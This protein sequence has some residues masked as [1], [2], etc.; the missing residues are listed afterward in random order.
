MKSSPSS[1]VLFIICLWT[2]PGS[3]E[4]GAEEVDIEEDILPFV[5]HAQLLGGQQDVPHHDVGRAHCNDPGPL[6]GFLKEVNVNTSVPQLLVEGNVGNVLV[7]A[8]PHHIEGPGHGKL[9]EGAALAAVEGVLVVEK[10]DVSPG[11]L[12]HQTLE[13]H[14]KLVP[15]AT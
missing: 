8:A 9:A 14:G 6:R 1:R 2:V 5:Q 15:R 4:V 7:P 12:T 13:E 11:E 3:L 10:C